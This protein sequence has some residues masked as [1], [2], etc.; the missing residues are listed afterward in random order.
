MDWLIDLVWWN[1]FD[2]EVFSR[3]FKNL[4]LPQNLKICLSESFLY[5]LPKFSCNDYSK[6]PHILGQAD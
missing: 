6:K 3:I 4:P 1:A 5:S 2:T